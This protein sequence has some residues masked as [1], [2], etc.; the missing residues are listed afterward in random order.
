D[1]GYN[2][3]ACQSQKPTIV[4]WTDDTY[5]LVGKDYDTAV[6]WAVNGS[7]KQGTAVNKTIIDKDIDAQIIH[8]IFAAAGVV[9]TDWDYPVTAGIGGSIE[10]VQG[11]RKQVTPANYEI[12]GKVGI[13]F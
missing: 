11:A 6:T 1:A 5:Y 7:A 8:K 4:D 2:V 12:F 13:S 3:Y 9:T 10:F